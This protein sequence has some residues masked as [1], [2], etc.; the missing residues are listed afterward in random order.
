MEVLDTFCKLNLKV[1]TNTSFFM[2]IFNIYIFLT[3]N[4]LSKRSI[5]LDACYKQGGK[6]TSGLPAYSMPPVEGV[7]WNLGL[8]TSHTYKA[9]YSTY[10]ICILSNGM[11]EFLFA[12]VPQLTFQWLTLIIMRFRLTLPDTT[13]T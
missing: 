12:D 8:S 4:I 6:R 5:R 1:S 9:L 10:R 11:K 7:S 3:T 2:H 13:D